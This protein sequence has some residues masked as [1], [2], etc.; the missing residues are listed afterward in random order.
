M[1]DDPRKP[2]TEGGPPHTYCLYATN[3]SHCPARRPNRTATERPHRRRRRAGTGV[4][5][6]RPG[7]SVPLGAR[8]LAVPRRAT[9]LHRRG[10]LRFR[11]RRRSHS[12][13]AHRA[14][15]RRNVP[16]PGHG[17]A[18]GGF[19]C[20]SPQAMPPTASGTWCTTPA[21]SPRPFAVGTR[22]SASCSTWCSPCSSWPGCHWA[23]RADQA[24]RFACQVL[25]ADMVWGGSTRTMPSGSMGAGPGRGRVHQSET[26]SPG[27]PAARAAA[28]LEYP[29]TL[30]LRRTASS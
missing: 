26:R 17:G 21:G 16:R 25:T 4:A 23:A 15:R 8:R 11:R 29:S 14:A 5:D 27:P 13:L 10:V 1:T 9:G 12:V 7:R 3:Q 18:L 6:G 30:D 24:S 20:S 28:R 22:P 19:S 2:L